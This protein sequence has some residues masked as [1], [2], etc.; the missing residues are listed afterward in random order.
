M[1]YGRVG[2]EKVKVLAAFGIPNIYALSLGDY[3][4][5]WMIAR[6]GGERDG[7]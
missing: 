5:D 4:G 7:T 1:I 2:A 6:V 3:H